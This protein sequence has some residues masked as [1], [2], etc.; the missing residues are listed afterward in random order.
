MDLKE[1]KRKGKTLKP[2]INLGK[3]GITDQLVIHIQKVLKQKKLIKIKINRSALEEKD[4]KEILNEILEKTGAKLVD[5][6]GFNAVL[7]KK[8]SSSEK[9]E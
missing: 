7:C 1:L 3:S 2:I 5:F 4:K 9:K 8:P 6:V